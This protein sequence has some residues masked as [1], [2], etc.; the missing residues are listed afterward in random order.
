MVNILPLGNRVLVRPMPKKEK[1]T[2]TLIIPAS[3][4]KDIEE[5]MVIRIGDAVIN[6]KE[7]DTVLYNSRNG[8]PILIEEVTYKFLTGPSSTDTGEIIAIL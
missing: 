2:G 6:V 7:G 5:A 3:I 4:N 8:T 1:T